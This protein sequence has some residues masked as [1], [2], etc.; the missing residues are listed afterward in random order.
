MYRFFV[1]ARIAFLI[2]MLLMVLGFLTRNAQKMF[3]FGVVSAFM[4]FAF[5]DAVISYFLPQLENQAAPEGMTRKLLALSPLSNTRAHATP[6]YKLFLAA[7]SLLGLV[8]VSAK[9]VHL[10]PI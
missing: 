1:I 5:L 7:F 2:L 10:S 3:D 4:L 9:V 8:W 6:T